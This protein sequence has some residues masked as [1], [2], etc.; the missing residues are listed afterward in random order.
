MAKE[1]KVELMCVM[2]LFPKITGRR[3]FSGREED[4]DKLL[5]LPVTKGSVLCGLVWCF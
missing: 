2:L 5:A 4:A 1:S 3:V